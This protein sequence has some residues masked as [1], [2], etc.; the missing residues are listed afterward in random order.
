MANNYKNERLKVGDIVQHFKRENSEDKNQ[1]LY[2][3]LGFAE[4]TKTGER[5]VLYQ[6]LYRN[7]TGVNGGIYCPYDMFMGEVDHE[8]YPNYTQKYI[9]ELIDNV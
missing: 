9:F 7:S 4:H 3:I 8:K 2:K 5:L 6:A 1:Y